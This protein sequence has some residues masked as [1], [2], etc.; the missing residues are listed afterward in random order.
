[1]RDA[2][3]IQ[4]L[5]RD[6]VLDHCRHPRNCRR[7]DAADRVAE[8]HNPLCGDKVTIYLRLDRDVVKEAAFEAVGCAISLA[9]ASMLT[10][11][12]RGKRIAEVESVVR[13]VEA[14]FGPDGERS[15]LARDTDIAALCGVRAYPSRIRCATLPW[16]TL[17][18][19]LQCR[20][21]AVSTE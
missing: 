1:M 13:E 8:G 18:A 4:A 15:A 19:A 6:K 2:A 20:K 10:E 12:V 21:T 16:H 14:L 3:D 17:H 7:I 11:M 9:S 5:Y